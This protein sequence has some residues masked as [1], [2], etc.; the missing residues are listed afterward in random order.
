MSVEDLASVG[1][2]L[3]AND[4]QGGFGSGEGSADDRNT[5]LLIGDPRRDQ[6]GGGGEPCQNLFVG[7]RKR[8][9]IDGTPGPDRIR[10]KRGRD[11][12]KGLGGDDC[13]LGGSGR[14]RLRG[15]DDDDVVNGGKGA[16]NLDGNAGA[17]TI[18]GGRG[19]DRVKSADGEVDV[20]KCGSGRD[21]AV[22]D[23]VDTVKRCDRVKRL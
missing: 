9:R 7:T 6:G 23:A 11:K 2:T 5:E 19:R 10:G 16:D 17:D 8:D 15:G 18:R 13:L 21:R 22:V 4:P 12:L 1:R 3:A 20:V 14:D